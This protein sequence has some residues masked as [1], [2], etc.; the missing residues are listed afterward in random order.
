MTINSETFLLGLLV[1]STLTG[2]VTEA[3]KKILTEH[4][5]SYHA[6]TLAGV[7]AMILSGGIGVGYVILNNIA[8][9]AQTITYLV[10]MVFV[11][12]LC[13]M[14]GYDKVIQA[15]K[16]FKMDKGDNKNE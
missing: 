14:V 10:V 2:L 6:N 13:S 4:N 3:V 5:I 7:I 8:F 11:S 12:W 15:I 1:L 16:Q 9:T